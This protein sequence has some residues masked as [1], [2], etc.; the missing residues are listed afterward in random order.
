MRRSNQ[1]PASGQER[2]PHASR[3]GKAVEHLVAASCILASDAQL[4]V[5]TSLVDDEGV[6]LVFHRRGATATL[7]VQVKS[8]SSDTTVVQ[9]R[10]FIANVRQATFSARDDLYMLFV[11]VHRATARLGPVWFI[12]ST[13]F[14]KHS[15]RSGSTSLRISANAGPAA[16]DRWLPYRMPFDKLPA[17]IISVLDGLEERE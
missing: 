14:E 10:R 16:S 9:R 3:I 2:S 6:D 12:R 15:T 13:E 4:N 1:E 5:S 8:R 11:V 7:A 17:R